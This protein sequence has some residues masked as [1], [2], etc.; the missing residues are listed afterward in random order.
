MSE[1][2]D[3]LLERFQRLRVWSVDGRRAPY[4]PL[5]ILWAIGRCLR[6]ESRLMTFE[7]TRTDFG[8]LVARFGPHRRSSADITHYPFWR[9]QHD[10]LWEIDRPQLVSM[11]PGNDAH[12][13]DLVRYRIRGGL[14]ESDYHALQSDPQL[15][16]RI[17]LNLMGAHFPETIHDYILDSVGISESIATVDDGFIETV[18]RRRPRTA[19]FRKSVLIAYDG[20]CAVCAMSLSM[21]GNPV[22]LE[23]AHIRW[24]AAEGPDEIR[25]GLALCVLHHKLFDLGAFT[26]LPNLSVFVSSIVKGRGVESALGQYHRKSILKPL[27]D[28]TE[29][30]PSLE[31]LLWHQ[32]EVFRSPHEIPSKS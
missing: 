28:S 9:L 30:Q 12:V 10:R 1:R 7:R 32:R 11:T 22:A 24:H 21:A 26:L 5:M 3:N 4:K 31:Y 6:G 17:A 19:A 15:A 27:P 29:S 16:W 14:T 23:A 8:E 18:V 13:S 20:K 25:N 2:A